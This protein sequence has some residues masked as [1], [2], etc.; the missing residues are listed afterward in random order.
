MSGD[1]ILRLAQLR[2]IK[3]STDLERQLTDTKGGGPVVEILRRL[4]EKAAESMLA[5]AIADAEDPKAIRIL[6]NEVKRY[7]EWCV[8]I[9]E[10]ISEGIAYDRAMSDEEREEILDLVGPDTP[11]EQELIEL[12]LADDPSR[13]RGD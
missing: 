7:D 5:L 1:P 4:R 8:W 13:G 12:G 10:I 2:I 11:A 3:N 9:T 6:Q